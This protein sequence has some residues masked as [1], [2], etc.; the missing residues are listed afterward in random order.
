MAE[1]LRQLPS[2][3]ARDLT[4]SLMHQADEQ[5]EAAA[6]AQS[7]VQAEAEA[8]ARGLY[9]INALRNLALSQARARSSSSSSSDLPT[10]LLTQ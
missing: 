8:V 3:A 2:H 6:E 9:P 4:L 10:Y 1:E 7:G 5:G